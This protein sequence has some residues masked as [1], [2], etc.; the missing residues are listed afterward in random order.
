MLRNYRTDHDIIRKMKC[1]WRPDCVKSATHSVN[2]HYRESGSQNIHY[3]C[4][5]HALM[6][7]SQVE[8]DDALEALDISKYE[9]P[10]E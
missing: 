3:Y 8:A 5:P 6:R 2:I 1:E 4:E 7:I 9:L 10:R